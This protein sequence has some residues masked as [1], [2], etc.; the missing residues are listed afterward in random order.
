MNFCFL[1]NLIIFYI[2]IFWIMFSI[3]TLFSATEKE[4]VIPQ[5]AKKALFAGGCFWCMEGIFEAQDG[6]YEAVSGY[7]WDSEKTANYDDVSSGVTKHRE[8]VQVSY[9]P[10]KISY[11]ALLELYWTQIDPT[12]PDGQFTDKWYQYTTAI[13]YQN[14]EEK[15][16]WQT[17]NVVK[18]QDK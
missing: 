9:D 14:E 18:Y 12:D 16:K 13:Y 7:A 5:N 15:K 6:V 4:K 8:V 17:K 10:E 3:N 1:H 11:E 2:L